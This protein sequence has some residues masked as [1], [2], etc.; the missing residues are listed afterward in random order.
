MFDSVVLIQPPNYPHRCLDEVARALLGASKDLG[1]LP[2]A[3]TLSSDPTTSQAPLVIGSCL[4]PH[5]AYP[6]DSIL[7]N[8]E[9]TGSGWLM[10]T[11]AYTQLLQ[12]HQVWDYD[13]DNLVELE[14]LGIKAKYCGIGY[15]ESLEDVPKLDKAID[16]LFYG[17]PCLRR[18]FV[19]RGLE[20]EGYEVRSHWF[21]YGE[22]KAEL[23]G[24]SK[25]VLNIH[26]YPAARFELVRVSHLL[27]N[28]VCVVSESGS[29]RV[30]EKYG[31][32]VR[33]ADYEKL[34]EIAIWALQKW[35]KQ[36]KVGQEIFKTFKQTTYLKEVL[37]GSL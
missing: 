29:S 8:L 14:K 22:R 19:L 25:V 34:I 12:H 5:L 36:G 23:I 27:A 24:R 33:F 13:Q 6:K 11:S 9:Q 7:L 4:A 20:S 16:F 15:H 3:A 1:I 2:A 32:A 17:S 21:L 28:G 30:E 31:I 26:Y 37:S 18:D 10:P 35:E